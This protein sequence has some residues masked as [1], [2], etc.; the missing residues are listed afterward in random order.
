MAKGSWAIEILSLHYRPEKYTTCSIAK[1]I[2]RPSLLL[3]ASLISDRYGYP[4]CTDFKL[5]RTLSFIQILKFS[6]RPS[7]VPHKATAVNPLLL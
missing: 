7:I 4:S 3:K 1:E 2:R 5:Y 6:K